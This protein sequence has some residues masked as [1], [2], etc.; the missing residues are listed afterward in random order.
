[1]YKDISI[2]FW[3]IF[4]VCT[5]ENKSKDHVRW[6]YQIT[7]AKKH[8]T[9]NCKVKNWN[10]EN[11]RLTTVNQTNERLTVDKEHFK[12]IIGWWKS[13]QFWSLKS[14]INGLSRPSWQSLAIAKIAQ[15]YALAKMRHRV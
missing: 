11:F 4:V 6:K 2:P 14:K 12:N 13:G 15:K 10:Q 9:R 8:S 3:S 5:H 1:V 7:T